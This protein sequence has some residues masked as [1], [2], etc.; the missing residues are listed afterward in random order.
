M[1]AHAGSLAPLLAWT[2]PVMDKIW[3]SVTSVMRVA[4]EA[5]LYVGFYVINDPPMIVAHTGSWA[6]LVYSQGNI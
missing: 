1:L 3:E 4:K 2:K 6:D 5:D